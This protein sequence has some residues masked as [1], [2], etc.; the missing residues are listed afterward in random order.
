LRLFTGLKPGASTEDMR[1]LLVSPLRQAQGRLFALRRM[2]HPAKT[3]DANADTVADVPAKAN[4][5]V[6]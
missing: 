3:G 5:C 6:H 2:G 1:R 4:A